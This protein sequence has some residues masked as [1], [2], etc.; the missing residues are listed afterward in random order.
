MPR[1]RTR[2]VHLRLVNPANARTRRNSGF[3]RDDRPQSN[4]VR[5]P[6]V[7]DIGSTALYTLHDGDNYAIPITLTEASAE[8]ITVHYSITDDTA[9]NRHRLYSS[10]AG[11]RTRKAISPWQLGHPYFPG[12]QHRASTSPWRVLPNSSR[13][14]DRWFT[15]TLR[16]SYRRR[17]GPERCDGRHVVGNHN[18]RRNLC[19]ADVLDAANEQQIQQPSQFGVQPF[20]PDA[21]PDLFTTPRTLPDHELGERSPGE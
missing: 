9:I 4:R 19:S 13:T 2:S 14:S 5:L 10:A 11:M 18:G 21:A 7:I 8:P 20:S 17:L 15:Y 1:F 6:S 16:R 3:R 12:V